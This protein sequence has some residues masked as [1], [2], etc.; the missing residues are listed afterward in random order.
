MIVRWPALVSSRYMV[1]MLKNIKDF[2]WDIAVLPHGKKRETLN[3]VIYWQ[4]LTLQGTR[5][6]LGVC[7]VLSGPEVQRII[8]SLKMTPI[9]IRADS[10]SFMNPDSA[11]NE[12][13]YIDAL[14]NSRP[15]PITM[16]M[17]IDGLISDAIQTINL[18]KKTVK[19]TLVEEKVRIDNHLQGKIM[20][21][22]RDEFPIPP[23]VPWGDRAEE[24]SR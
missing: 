6:C 2:D 10:D 3:N 5:C 17:R 15:F 21:A 9:L 19:Q 1:P 8:S 7:E 24:F 16:D 23:G 4:F 22:L 18:G 20:V 14:K 13:I 11:P 12:Q